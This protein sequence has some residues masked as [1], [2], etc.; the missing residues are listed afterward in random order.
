MLI[1]GVA[2]GIAAAII[3][4][5]LLSQASD[6]AAVASPSD[7]KALET[8][9]GFVE[10]W[11]SYDADAAATYMSNDAV[12]EF[13]GSMEAM[14]LEARMN[15]AQGQKWA[16]SGCEL[17]NS[18]APAGTLVRCP[19]D[20][21]A[22]ESDVIGRGPYPGSFLIYVSDGEIVRVSDRYLRSLYSREV[23]QPFAAWVREVYPA[24]P[25]LMWADVTT[26]TDLIDLP[27]LSEESIMLWEQHRQEWV[28]EGSE[29]YL[30]LA[31]PRA[32]GEI[33]IFYGGLPPEDAVPSPSG[34]G[35]IVADFARIHD[36]WVFV[37][38]DGRVLWSPDTDDIFE[39]QLTQDGLD[40]VL[41]GELSPETLIHLD[42]IPASVVE[43]RQVRLFIPSKY[44]TCYWTDGEVDATQVVDLLPESVQPLLRGK[45]RTFYPVGGLAE[46]PPTPIECHEV[47]TDEARTVDEALE[48]AGVGD[49]FGVGWNGIGI[50]FT[51][52]LPHGQW[53]AWGG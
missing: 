43:N 33:G 1:G 21:H 27:L 46:D 45:E 29:R 44:A 13:G 5:G 37:Y 48:A 52:L 34:S 31:Y 7:Q 26:A 22:L 51:P 23:L 49:P 8:A 41:S 38:S 12:V 16:L 11:T 50:Q 4:I 20:F 25:S 30:T 32:L 53:V 36:G 28:D 10:A 42:S 40:L 18:I 47:T 35:E 3:G 17:S 39:L 24:H 14:R 6:G 9:T 19:Y 2:I 15:E